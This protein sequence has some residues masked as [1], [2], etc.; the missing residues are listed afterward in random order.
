MDI[1]SVFAAMQQ[2]EQLA[3][4]PFLD[5]MAFLRCASLLKNNILQPQ[6][7]TVSDDVDVLWNIL[8]D[9]VWMLPTA[10]EAAD[11]EEETF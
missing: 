11:E 10:G 3:A 2:H 6:P 5:L 4:M 7:H 8:K 1:G 9:L